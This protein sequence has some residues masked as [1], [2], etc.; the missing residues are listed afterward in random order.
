MS[1]IIEMN[2]HRKIFKIGLFGILILLTPIICGAS[3]FD[4]I[5]K[6]AM[7]TLN[8]GDKDS[9]QH[10]IKKL[11]K[12]VNGLTKTEREKLYFAT[13]REMDF[14]DKNPFSGQE[15]WILIGAILS[16]TKDENLI[17]KILMISPPPQVGFLRLEEYLK[18]VD[19]S[20]IARVLQEGAIERAKKSQPKKPD[21][22]IPRDQ[23]GVIP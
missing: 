1:S 2:N 15:N 7:L 23:K 3:K 13:I 11:L 22:V 16:Q 17:H 19:P 14:G 20:I 5:K 12:S 6:Q 4:E 18:T 10:S 9:H 8:S 21:G